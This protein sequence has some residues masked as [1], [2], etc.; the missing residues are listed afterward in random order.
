MLHAFAV[1]VP[2]GEFCFATEVTAGGGLEDK[3]G[4]LTVVLKV[5]AVAC[6]G[7]A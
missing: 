5:V 1:P 4:T 2:L 6:K 7:L 3:F